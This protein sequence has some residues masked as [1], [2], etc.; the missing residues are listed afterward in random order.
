MKI[1]K[2]PGVLA[3]LA[4]TALAVGLAGSAPAQA[5][6]V[7]EPT[8]VNQAAPKT[9]VLDAPVPKFR[10]DGKPS[11]VH[12]DTKLTDPRSGRVLSYGKNAPNTLARGTEG[13]K[14][15]PPA[16][17]VA[18]KAA[19]STSQVYRYAGMTQNI[20]AGT[21]ILGAQATFYMGKPFL[22]TRDAHSLS[23]IAVQQQSSLST[24]RD[25]VEVGMN[26]DRTVNAGS[27]NTHLFVYHWVDGAMTCYNGCGFVD[28]G[29]NPVNAGANVT[30][31]GWT[32]ANASV[33]KQLSLFYDN[34]AGC[35][36]CGYWWAFADDWI[37]YYP[38]TV[39]AT[40]GNP[41]Q[42]F[43]NTADTVQMFGEVTALDESTT[44]P[45]TSVD[46]KC[47]DMGTG[48][49]AAHTTV[50]SPN[51]ARIANAEYHY[52]GGAAGALP[53]MFTY[54]VANRWTVQAISPGT[55][56][57]TRGIWYGGPGQRSNGAVV[58]NGVIGGC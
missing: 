2:I 11:K 37:G 35:A 41:T 13:I 40:S 50:Q 47:T 45:D 52:A 30:A 15:P 5:R 1:K 23:E 36:G 32:N 8:V 4:V 57:N 38:E 55:S 49:W 7:L 26:V 18:G 17:P 54:Q 22:D 58:P 48:A 34:Q 3:A 28:W 31:L 39:F 29:P 44:N 43:S 10:P 42:T 27:T 9:G 20:A 25:I 14:T 12:P 51:A 33:A 56:V 53:V 21:G 6:P 24:T 46:P 19:K 16:P